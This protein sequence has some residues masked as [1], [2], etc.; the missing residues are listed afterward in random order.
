MF[1]CFDI[2]DSP[3]EKRFVAVFTVI[4]V[5]FCLSFYGFWKTFS[6]IDEIT[7]TQE[8]VFRK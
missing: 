5:M 1:V 7:V 2:F 8:N 4:A 3:F 6:A